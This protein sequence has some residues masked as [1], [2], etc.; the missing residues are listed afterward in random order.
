MLTD[1]IKREIINGFELD[2]MT[3]F[4]GYCVIDYNNKNNI[5]IL[6]NEVYGWLIECGF[7]YVKATPHASCDRFYVEATWKDKPR[8][9]NIPYNKIYRIA[10]CCNI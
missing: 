2:A 6:C 1:E 4:N 3:G 5:D 10:S 8:Y 9:S 7:Q